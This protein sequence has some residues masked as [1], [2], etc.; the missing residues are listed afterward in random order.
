MNTLDNCPSR[1]ATLQT[2]GLSR[3]AEC[4]YRTLLGQPDLAVTELAPRLGTDPAAVR[5]AL[6]ELA[7]LALVSPSADLP[8]R[9]RPA[10]P[11]IGLQALIARRQAD[12]ERQQREVANGRLMVAR[13]V[14][15]YTDRIRPDQLELISN[16]TVDAAAYP[17]AMSHLFGTAR[18]SALACDIDQAIVNNQ[19]SDETLAGRFAFAVQ[20]LNAS[21]ALRG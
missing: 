1:G 16:A 2:L 15:E 7:G 18:M 5:G 10:N 20:F 12:L 13:M 6:D 14:S 11:E 9:F 17:L 3:A 19:R 21:D 4:V 8:G